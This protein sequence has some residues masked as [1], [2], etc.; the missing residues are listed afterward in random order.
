M[1]LSTDRSDTV[2][3]LAVIRALVHRFDVSDDQAFTLIADT[4]TSHWDVSLLFQPE[5]VW[6]R[7]A[8]H[9][10]LKV[11][12][13]AGE[14][15][16]VLRFLADERFHCGWEGKY[17]EREWWD[18]YSSHPTYTQFVSQILGSATEYTRDD[19]SFIAPDGDDL[20]TRSGERRVRKPSSTRQVTPKETWLCPSIVNFKLLSP[21]CVFTYVGVEPCSSSQLALRTPFCFPPR[22]EVNA[23]KRV[24]LGS[25]YWRVGKSL[26][27]ARK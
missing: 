20:S 13:L 5:D 26:K 10:A 19:D 18:I 4:G 12:R 3:R 24:L 1:G 2:V 8:S 6:L 22:N 7:I 9:H 27:T 17:V 11:D 23:I 16:L 15:R 25:I 14:N 21:M